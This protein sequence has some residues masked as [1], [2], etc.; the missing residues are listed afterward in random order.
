MPVGARSGADRPAGRADPSLPAAMSVLLQPAGAG[1]RR[2]RAADR[3]LARRAGPGGR[4]RRAAGP[5]LRRRADRAPRP[6]ADRRRRPPA[7]LYTNLIT[8]AVLLTRERLEELADAG[9]DHVQISIQDARARQRRPHRRLRGRAR[10]EAARWPAGCGELGLPLTVN[11]VVH[12]QNIDSLPA[13]IDWPSSSARTGSRWRT[14]SITAGRC[15]T[16]A[17]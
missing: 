4:A 11:A 17:P 9:L 6:R 14:S 2:R 16:G 8:A 10:Q 12:R 13:M 3:G 7:G 1:A 15:R 5:S